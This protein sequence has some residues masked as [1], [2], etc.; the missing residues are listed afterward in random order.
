MTAVT[1][2]MP[3]RDEERT[4]AGAIASVL[5]QTYAELELLVVD[6]DSTDGTARLVAEIA[7]RDHRVRLLR[8]PARTIP[9]ALNVGLPQ[10]RGRYLA[11][12]DAHAS[13]NRSY[14]RR[15][16]ATLDAE[17]EIAAVGGRRFGVATSPSGVAIAAAVSSRYGVGDSINHY[18]TTAQDTDHA[19]FGVYRVAVLRE[20][21]GWD[22]DLIVN[23]DVDLDHR[24]L[25]AG[26]RI[27]YDPDMCIFWHVRESLPAVV[28]QYRRY[29]RGKALMIRKN[30]RSAMRA[31]HAAPP[32]L[33][34]TLAAAG[35]VS[36][37]G[38]W[39]L[40]IALAAPYLVAT[41]V[42]TAVTSRRRELVR[43]PDDPT[44]SWTAEPALRPGAQATTQ[45]TPQPGTQHGTAT[46]AAGFTRTAATRVGDLSVI[47]STSEADPARSGSGT[48]SS[49]FAS[50]PPP[51]LPAVRTVLDLTD[52]VGPSLVTV[53]DSDG[54]RRPN[55]VRLAGAFTAMHLSWGL[56]FVESAVFG[57]PPADS[58]ARLPRHPPRV[59]RPAP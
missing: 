22:P 55:A 6:G 51:A 29:G 10:A 48:A 16:V 47:E 36:A 9:C 39:P 26:H 1:V 7:A 40:G 46:P 11:R 20:V 41:T 12:V 56:G 18:A 21:G 44:L 38:L 14:L 28:R 5:A 34:A 24:V 23:E 54:G 32:V 31:R 15:A 37:V 27:H 3:V 25:G 17:P 43:R 8:N 50:A 59:A 4:V 58:S 53:G 13:I 35:A 52:T 49:L 2:V 57:L 33:L 45:P 42:A 19:S 30:G